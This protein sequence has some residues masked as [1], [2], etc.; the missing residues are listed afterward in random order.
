MCAFYF[1][2]LFKKFTI[3]NENDICDVYL[4]IWET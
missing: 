4:K 3:I 1:Q 2:I